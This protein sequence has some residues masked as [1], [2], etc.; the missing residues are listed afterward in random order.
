M[1][2]SAA[3][4][5]FAEVS[6]KQT[7]ASVNLAGI[8]VGEFGEL[9]LDPEDIIIAASGTGTEVERDSI[10]ANAPGT[11]L[12]LDVDSI[13]GFDGRFDACGEQHDH[14][15]CEDQQA[16]GQSQFDCRR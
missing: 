12:T 6:G 16:D 5:G 3:R 1:G 15:E 8:D 11:T 10:A 9:L 14:G 7:L 13:N 2:I 4:G